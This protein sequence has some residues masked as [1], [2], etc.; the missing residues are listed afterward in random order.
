MK[1]S[2]PGDKV[3]M[4]FDHNWFNARCFEEMSQLICFYEKKS[5]SE[6]LL[7]PFHAG[8]ID[9]TTRIK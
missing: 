4:A 5:L 2:L 6:Q 3:L 8:L 1:I 7:L 9:T